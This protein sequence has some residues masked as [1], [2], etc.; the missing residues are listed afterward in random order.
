MNNTPFGRAL[1]GM[2]VVDK[3]TIQPVG[4]GDWPCEYLY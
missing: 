1:N 4:E 3:L 2:D